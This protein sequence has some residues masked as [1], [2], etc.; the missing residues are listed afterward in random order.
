MNLGDLF[1]RCLQCG[2]IFRKY[3]RKKQLVTHCPACGAKVDAQS[4]EVRP[5]G[6]REVR[7]G[8]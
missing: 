1:A 2:H 4:R 7:D 5:V 6:N 8:L 3:D